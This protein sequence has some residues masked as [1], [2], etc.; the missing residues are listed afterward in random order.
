MGGAIKET[1]SNE[2]EFMMTT[3]NCEL[4]ENIEEFTKWEDSCEP[5]DFVNICNIDVVELMRSDSNTPAINK[6][7][8]QKKFFKT[9]ITITN[10]RQRYRKREG[11]KY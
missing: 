10:Y 1:V 3:T 8:K 6:Q 5:Y 9:K 7:K 2:V 11:F 4:H